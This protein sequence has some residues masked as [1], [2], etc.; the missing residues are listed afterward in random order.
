MSTTTTDAP[1]RTLVIGDC[2]GHRD[3]LE[4]LLKQE[5]ILSECPDSGM[6]RRNYDDVEVVQL[7]DLGHFGKSQA[8]DRSIWESGLKWIDVI[9]W[10]NHDRAVVDKD[11]HFFVGY[12]EP[13]PDTIE[14]LKKATKS[15][16]L[17]LAHEAHGFLLTH[18]GLHSAYKYNKG[19]QG[20]A[21]AIANWL[22]Q[23]EHEDSRD[24]DFLA[25]RDAV[26]STRGG[27]SPYGG[28]LWRDCSE[29]LYDPVRQVFGHS[30]KDK[31]RQ[32]QSKGKRD[33]FCIDVGNQ[34]NGRLAA[35]WLPDETV[36]EVE[37]AEDAEA[38]K[39]REDTER[40]V[41]EFWDDPREPWRNFIV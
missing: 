6:V 29:S 25:V 2:H 15:K 22:N 38:R 37:I 4:A 12:E 9:L 24:E 30:S 28:I 18:A 39:L 3:R 32:Y 19:P 23:L 40:K 36:V 20:D 26:G 14:L 33:S 5:G 31:V 1:K 34:F 17:R 27:R 16:Q 10:G 7:G 8:Q 13:F 35:I 11:S 21:T 41:R